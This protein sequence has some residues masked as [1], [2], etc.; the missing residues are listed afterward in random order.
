MF[1]EKGEGGDW[2]RPSFP[3]CKAALFFSSNFSLEKA[4]SCGL[5]Y[6]NDVLNF[7]EN[8]SFALE[9]S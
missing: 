4:M 8:F 2:N 5:E 3:H 7:K 6:V 9:E 1:T